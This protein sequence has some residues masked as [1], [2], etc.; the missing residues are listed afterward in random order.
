VE[1][2]LSPLPNPLPGGR[3][4]KKKYFYVAARLSPLPKGR[5]SKEGKSDTTAGGS[6]VDNKPCL[7]DYSLFTFAK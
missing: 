7:A 5:G 6:D 1:A 2:H 3:G 4:S